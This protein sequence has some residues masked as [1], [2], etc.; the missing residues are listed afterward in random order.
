MHFL[1]YDF[2][3]YVKRSEPL[4]LKTGCNHLFEISLSHHHGGIL[5]FLSISTAFL[6]TITSM[7]DYWFNVLFINGFMPDVTECTLTKRLF[8]QPTEYLAKGLGHY[9]TVNSKS[10]MSL[11]FFLINSGFSPWNYSIFVQ[12]FFIV[13]WTLTSNEATDKSSHC[14]GFYYNLL[15]ESFSC[16]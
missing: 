6:R 4:N 11:C 1:N 13:S 12:C 15:D 2:W 7:F 16:S 5:A 3:P 10:E 14:S 9:Q 8:H